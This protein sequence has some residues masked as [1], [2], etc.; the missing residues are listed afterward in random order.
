MPTEKNPLISNL[1]VPLP[2]NKTR[3]YPKLS[4]AN[5]TTLKASGID[6]PYALVEIELN[7]GAGSPVAD[8]FAATRIRKLDGSKDYPIQA[9]TAITDFKKR[10]DAYLSEKQ[11]DLD[12]AMDEAAKKAIKDRTP[13][14][15]RDKSTVMFITWMSETESLQVRFLTRITDGDYRYKNGIKIELSPP[16]LPAPPPQ[17][18]ELPPSQLENGLRY[19]MQFGVEFGAQFEMSKAGK[20]APVKLLE[21]QAFQKEILAP[22]LGKRK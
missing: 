2:D 21:V 4:M 22:A 3:V 1:S 11:K 7:D 19:G 15:P 16:A 13:T 9:A 20:I 10:Y 17:G 14:G 8:A 18:G 6:A 12:A 5:P